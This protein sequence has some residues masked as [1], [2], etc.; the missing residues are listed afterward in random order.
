MS[1]LLLSVLSLAVVPQQDLSQAVTFDAP[2]SQ[3]SVVLGALSKRIGIPLDTTPQTKDAILLVHVSKAPLKELLAKVAEVA[4]AEWKANGSGFTLY[5][6]GERQN[7]SVRDERDARGAESQR[8]LDE[9]LAKHRELGEWSNEAAN[10]LAKAEKD[11]LDKMTSTNGP[12]RIVG[13]TG[14]LGSG[15]P[16]ERVV[17]RLLAAIGA[18]RLG[19]VGEG[20]R[21]V[22]GLSPTRM[23]VA[24]PANSSVLLNAFVD[25]QRQYAEAAKRLKDQ[26][27]DT[28]RSFSIAGVSNSEMGVGDPTLGIGQAILVLTRRF[29]QLQ[30]NLTVADRNGDT[31]AT[32]GL[33]L[34]AP[35]QI[36]ASNADDVLIPISKLGREYLDTN[37]APGGSLA[38]RT[39]VGI[40]MVASSSAGVISFDN[41]YPPP[42][43]LISLELRKW[44]TNPEENDPEA[45]LVGPSFAFAASHTKSNLVACLPDVSLDSIGNTLS[46]GKLTV[47]GLLTKTAD[48]AQL[49]VDRKD[50]WI[51]VW[52]KY[53]A[54]AR[55][56]QMNRSALGKLYRAADKQGFLR[57]GDM[58][59]YALAQ[60][61]PLS[62]GDY[63]GRTLGVLSSSAALAATEAF[64]EPNMLRLFGSL[65]PGQLSALQA[66]RSLPVAQL[67]SKQQGFLFDE[68]YRSLIGPQLMN[69]HANDL[70]SRRFLPFGT[71]GGERT[72]LLPDG[73][74]RDA[75]VTLK[76]D[77]DIA[78]YG[79]D[80]RTGAA[81]FV[82]PSRMASNL[83]AADRADMSFLGEAPKFDRF[84][85][86]E[87][88]TYALA[89][90]L[91]PEIS[92]SRT[93]TDN[94][95]DLNG[96]RVAYEG[97]SNDFR[98][99]T[100]EM[101]K[102]LK[103]S[104]AN[105]K[106]P[107]VGRSGGNGNIPPR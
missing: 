47:G 98:S 94:W 32:A 31:I 60:S 72:Q 39:R 107:A 54:S 38:P 34:A 21:V 12:I 71:V 62:T 36:P 66:G 87:Q 25:Q 43:T 88:A 91:N 46:L 58:T 74:P 73:I 103:E 6:D 48:A 77:R 35:T 89:I 68:V 97:L 100:A 70:T 26:D 81:G 99:K 18:D 80:S 15:T 96:P 59:A 2:A 57:L 82:T 45:L 4:E 83:Y 78:A 86:A 69:A 67:S 104:L 42:S 95:A 102:S 93:L 28:S 101:L 92:L 65:T 19:S 53:G 55:N 37:K 90:N 17:A 29:G 9:V 75:I 27:G 85:Q 106:F 5:R 50:G 8:A 41:N 61:K 40:R 22:F 105:M 7:R 1:S 30:A 49:R 23:Q 14:R 51:K 56:D 84:A 79:V 20:D 63:D 64:M 76:V 44:L 13:G 11:A 52:P 10:R 3:A 33:N 16:G 24:M